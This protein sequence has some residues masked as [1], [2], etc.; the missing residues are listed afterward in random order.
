MTRLIKF[1]TVGASGALIGLATLWLL[2]ELAGWH[3]LLS[4]LVAFILSVGNNYLWNSLWTFK[5]KQAHF[6]GLSKY[7]LVSLGTLGLR[8]AMMYIFTD[9]GGIWYMASAV[10][11][12][13]LAASVNFVLSRRFVWNKSKADYLA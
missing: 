10:L 3:Y 6:T 11:V 4:Y 13:V 8:E 12:T 9:I 5:D 2:T 7:A 1:L